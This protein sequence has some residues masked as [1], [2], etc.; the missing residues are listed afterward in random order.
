MDAGSRMTTPITRK[1]P[2]LFFLSP[3]LFLFP[4]HHGTTHQARPPV[5]LSLM[6]HVHQI[7]V[8]QCPRLAVEQARGGFSPEPHPM[9]PSAT[10]DTCLMQHVPRP[11]SHKPHAAWGKAGERMRERRHSHIPSPAD[12]VPLVLLGC[13]YGGCG[14]LCIAEDIYGEF[15]RT[16]FWANEVAPANQ[17]IEHQLSLSPEP[18]HWIPA[19]RSSPIRNKAFFAQQVCAVWGC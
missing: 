19:G 6:S 10:V 16:S 12:R 3:H 14:L 5:S 9:L 7:S 1:Q 2:C 11:D 18:P 13:L 8:R 17:E 4:R 15:G